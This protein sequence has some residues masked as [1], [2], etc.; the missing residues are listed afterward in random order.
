MHDTDACFQSRLRITGLQGLA[1][2]FN[3]PTVS[4]VM[5][6]EDGDEGRLASTVFAKQ[7]KNFSLLHLQRNV[8]IGHQTAK[9]FGDV[10]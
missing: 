6:E 10:S 7:S 8:V 4:N 1:I 3:A 9:T 2:N 5:A